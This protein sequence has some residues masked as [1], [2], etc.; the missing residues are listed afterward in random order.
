MHLSVEARLD[1]ILEGTQ[2]GTWEWNL[3]SDEFICDERWAY[4]LGYRLDELLPVSKNTLVSFCHPDDRPLATSVFEAFLSGRETRYDT[5]LRFR[6]KTD[7]WRVIH[8]RAVLAK[9]K[10]PKSSRWLVGSNED[11]TDEHAAKHQIELLS[12]SMPGLI[13]SFVVQPD[14]YSY[15]SYISKKVEEFYGVTQ[16]MAKRDA[17]AVYRAVLPEDRPKIEK[18]L[19]ECARSMTQWRCDYRIQARDGMKWMRAIATPEEDSDGSMSWQG[20]VINIDTEKKFELA[21]EQLSITD[22]LS[23]LYNRRFLFQRLD[24]LIAIADRYGSQFSL[25]SLDIDHFK[26]VNDTYGHMEGDRVIRALGNLM[27][28]RLRKSDI[29]ARTGGEEFTI[30][31]PNTDVT[32]ARQV[33]EDLKCSVSSKTFGEVDRQF[34]VSFSAGLVSYPKDASSLRLLMSR[35]DQLLYEAKKKGRNQIVVVQ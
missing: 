7:G 30:V 31:M 19:A 33:A 9:S 28:Q 12:E 6:H 26:M 29:A 25:L 32:R 5:T 18:S 1:A 11:I 10:D 13:Y 24:E 34:V 22:E 15:F 27:K 4:M 35:C 23:G 14:G 8:T 21:L 17:M 2:A 16:E 20:V 3:D